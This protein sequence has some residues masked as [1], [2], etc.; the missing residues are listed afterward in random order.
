VAQRV[1]DDAGG[2]SKHTADLMQV[3]AELTN[4]RFFGART[5]QQPPIVRPRIQG[6][7]EPKALDEFTH[8]GIHGDHPFRFEP[9]RS[10]APSA[11]PA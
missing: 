2:E 3:I 6:T 9:P 7:K 11:R 1:R 10:K 8:R 4:E 5:G